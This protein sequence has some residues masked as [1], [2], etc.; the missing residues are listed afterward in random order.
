MKLAARDCFASL[1]MTTKPVIARSAAT[2]QSRWGLRLQVKRVAEAEEGGLAEGF[3]EGRVDVDRVRDIVEHPAHR[4]RM[5][6]FAREL[7]DLLAD[8]LDAENALIIAPR[9]D[10]DKAAARAGFERQGTPAGGERKDRNGGVDARS[11]GLVR[12]HPGDDDLG[13]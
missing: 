7:G 9:D 1:A 4:Q 12:Q 11:S 3:A 6:E 5:G 2:K 8:R 10:P 13:V